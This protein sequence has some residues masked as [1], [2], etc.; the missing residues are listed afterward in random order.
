MPLSD[1]N[2]FYTDQNGVI[3]QWI[4]KLQNH[5]IEEL[6][7]IQNLVSIISV[8]FAYPPFSD[9]RRFSERG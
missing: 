8:D 1:R 6:P 4:C 5:F 2:I 3:P 7:N 9:G